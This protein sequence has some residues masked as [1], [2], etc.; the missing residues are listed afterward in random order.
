[1]PSTPRG[2]THFPSQA[3]LFYY[4]TTSSTSEE[5]LN[6]GYAPPSKS[7]LK[8][9]V[10][11]LTQA[12][13]GLLDLAV[14]VDMLTMVSRNQISRSNAPESA[15]EEAVDEID[16]RYVSETGGS[17]P[18]TSGA[19]IGVTNSFDDAPQ[20]DVLIVPGSFSSMDVPASVA[21]FIT[22]QAPDLIA[23]LSI[24]SGI[25][26]LAQTNLLH[27]KRATGPPQLLPALRQ[28]R[29]SIHWQDSPWTRQDRIWSSSSAFTAVDMM[30]A[31]VREYFWDR[32]EAVEYALGTAGVPRLNEDES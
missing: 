16:I 29:P 32:S 6:I 30:T 23:V 24:S 20:F 13:L 27:E 22:H 12:Q 31:F 5:D 26:L 18:V 28:R 25:A 7:S 15:L 17:F 14:P 10:L 11:V 19:R 4:L 21:A 9:G 3:D 2:Y 8:V 1:M